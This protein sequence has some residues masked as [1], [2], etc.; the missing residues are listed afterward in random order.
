MKKSKIFII[1]DDDKRQRTKF[2]P[3]LDII[4]VGA[5]DIEW[6]H[7]TNQ[8]STD[9]ITLNAACV[10]LHTTTRDGIDSNGKRF[11][12]EQLKIKLIEQDIPHVLFSNTS[13]RSTEL[14]DNLTLSMSSDDFYMN[15][16]DFIDNVK[17][18]NMI[19]LEVLALGKNYKREKINHQ[20][21]ILISYFDQF[22]IDEPL[23]LN[24]NRRISLK[25]DLNIFE[26]L[27]QEELFTSVVFRKLNS[28]T[29]TLLYFEQ[30]MNSIIK[31]IR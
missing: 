26:A 21:T 3:F 19:D 14:D 24:E 2:K 7:R 23:S 25:A 17:H 4:N 28:D 30:M 27:T 31:F 18:N 9:D 6:I 11:D 22:E 16:P 20:K 29:L 8:T 10:C 13:N 5:N 12:F 1:D 15:L